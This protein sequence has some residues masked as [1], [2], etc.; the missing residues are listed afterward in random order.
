[1]ETKKY[2]MDCH[3]AGR[4]YHNADEVWDQL[5][6]GTKLRLVREMDNRYD[7]EAVAVYY[8]RK[9]KNA[10]PILVGYIPRDENTEI[11]A[12][13]EMGWTDLFECTINRI[14]PDAHPERQV[15]LTIKVKR[16]NL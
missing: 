1:M 12:I 13:L 6:I 11:A 4:M 8:D 16:N 10:E 15:H 3:L 14:A 9:G 7:P 2:F 5:K